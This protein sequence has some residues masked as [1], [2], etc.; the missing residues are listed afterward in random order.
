MTKKE[1]IKMQEKSRLAIKVH[2]KAVKQTLWALPENVI[3]R[4]IA[5][6]KATQLNVLKREDK[7]TIR[8]TARTGL[9]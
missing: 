9:M 8:Q 4:S 7:I 1:L 5:M 3:A 6:I 2:K